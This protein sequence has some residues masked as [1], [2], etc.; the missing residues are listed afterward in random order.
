MNKS[1]TAAL[2][3]VCLLINVQGSAQSLPAPWT[4]RD[5]GSPALAGS[6][7]FADGSFTV[8]AA[9][10]DIGHRTDQFYFV[11]Q[12]VS[13]DVDLRVKVESLTRVHPLSTAGIM[14]RG[15]LSADAPH[16]SVLVSP[17]KGTTFLRRRTAASNSRQSHGGRSPGSIRLVRAG[18]TLTAYTS[19]DGVTWTEIASDTVALGDTAYVGLA[20]TS[21]NPRERTSAEIS[22]VSLRSSALP[23]GQASSDIGDPAITGSASFAEGRYSIQAGGAGIWDSADQF[24]YLYQAVTGDVEVV[25]RIASLSAADQWSKAGVMIRESLDPGSRHAFALTSA[26][27]G[28]VFQRRGEPAGWSDSTPG[29]GGTAPGWLRLVRR[30]T[31]FEAYRSDDGES[32]TPMGSD[33]ISMADTV[34]VGLAVASHDPALATTAVVDNLRVTAGEAATNRP[35]AVILSAPADGAAL[36]APATLTASAS[37]ADPDGSISS[38]AFYANGTLLGRDTTAPYTVSVGSVPEGA[39]AITAVATDDL[40]ASAV[41]DSV[42]ILVSAASAPPPPAPPASEPPPSEP[43]P[44]PAPSEPPPAADAPRWVAFTASA[45][46]DSLVRKYVLEVYGSSSTPGASKPVATSDLGKPAP[47]ASGDVF[48]DRAAFFQALPPGAYLATVVAVGDGASARSES[49]TFTR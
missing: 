34:Y 7:T 24:H 4:A 39:Y 2:V 15:S 26:G 3:A 10:A 44:G 27:A 33:V 22:N 16:G 20:V 45:D 31:L 37:A 5:I 9:G 40:G 35:P 8:D 36:V 47:A 19:D 38:V 13:G 14:I 46:H 12:A 42:N 6:A 28:H 1:M 17:A 18:T 11:Y 32:W 43:P 48:V 25:A 29:G 21:R 41:S 23:E 30:G 49:V